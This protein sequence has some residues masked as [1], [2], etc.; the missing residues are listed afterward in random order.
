MDSTSEI[1]TYFFSD[2]GVIPN[3]SSLPVLMYRGVMRE[4]PHETER[5][6]NDNGWLNSWT[7]G[8]F[9][10]HHYHSNSHEVLGVISGTVTVQLGGPNGRHFVL[11]VGDVVVLPA[12]TGHRRIRASS[13]LSV[14]GA[15]PDGSDYNLHTEHDGNR[16]DVLQEI[17]QVPLPNTDP[18]AGNDGPLIDLW[19]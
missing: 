19:K 12:G 2:D 5:L 16:P 1:R 18:I 7:N 9:D 6:F 13:D 15:Y 17:K 11:H 4:Q 8:I 10:Y 3:N 14:V